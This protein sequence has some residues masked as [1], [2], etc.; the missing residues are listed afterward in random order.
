MGKAKLI[1]T[2][3]FVLAVGTGVVAGMMVTRLPTAG[4]GVT[5]APTPLGQE[6][7]LTRDQSEKMRTIWEGTRGKVDECF[8]TAQ[9]I[10]KK[11]DDALVALLTEEQKS[12]FAKIQQD[13]TDALAGLKNDRDAVFQDAVKQTEMILNADQQKRYREILK[14]RGLGHG[15]GAPPDWIAP[16]AVTSQPSAAP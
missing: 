5:T 14:S 16:R 13:Y 7:G 8:V 6:L 9:T 3:L 10:Q 1:L 15:P 11:R 4:A 2:L 12:R